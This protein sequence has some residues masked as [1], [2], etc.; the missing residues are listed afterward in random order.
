MEAVDV[1]EKHVTLVSLALD[2]P[3]T[4]VDRYVDATNIAGA[5]CRWQVGPAQLLLPYL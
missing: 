3:F 5:L 1:R 4:A 2:V